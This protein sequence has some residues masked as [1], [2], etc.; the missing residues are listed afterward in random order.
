MQLGFNGVSRRPNKH[1]TQNQKTIN[2]QQNTAMFLRR[3]KPTDPINSSSQPPN[4]PEDAGIEFFLFKELLAHIDEIENH[5]LNSQPFTSDAEFL[6]SYEYLFCVMAQIDNIKKMFQSANFTRN[7]TKML[8]DELTRLELLLDASI[9][10]RS[11]V[12]NSYRRKELLNSDDEELREIAA[13]DCLIDEH[14]IAAYASVTD[15]L[16]KPFRNRK[17]EEAEEE[18]E[19]SKEPATTNEKKPTREAWTPRVIRMCHKLGLSD[20]EER[21]MIYILVAQC[22]TLY[23]TIDS[24]SMISTAAIMGKFCQMT[25]TELIHFLSPSRLHCKQELIEIESQ[26]RDTLSGSLIKMPKE[27]MWALLGAQLSASEF[28]KIDK[29]VVAEVLL[30]EPG[31][32]IHGITDNEQLDDDEN[33]AKTGEDEHNDDGDEYELYPT[34]GEVQDMEVTRNNNGKKETDDANDVE[35]KQVKIDNSS[36]FDLYDYLKEESAKNDASSQPQESSTTKKDILLAEEQFLTPYKTDIEYLDDRFQFLSSR[37]KIRNMESEKKEQESDVGYKVRDRSTDSILRE[38]HAKE[39]MLKSKSV[40]RL[41]NSRSFVPRLERL[42]KI[43]NLDEFEKMIL[44]LLVAA[45][46]SHDVTISVSQSYSIRSPKDITVGYVLWILCDTLEER[47]IHRRYFYKKASLVKDGMIRISD[48]LSGD[49][50]ECSVNIDRRMLDYIAGLDSE[51]SE[52]VEGSNLYFPQ[53]KLENVILPEE[54]KKLIIDT[55][56]NFEV[57]KQHRKKLGFDDLLTYGTSLTLMFF[58]A[59]GVG[60]VCFCA[61]DL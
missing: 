25:P 21:A 5:D 13:Q 16:S 4:N 36:E 12:T 17:D 45:I 52:I 48:L 26:Y 58:G 59:S 49:L 56:S 24:M 60:K 19:A 28:L 7:E 50:T 42:A 46:I 37:I 40:K 43:R 2:T 33:S 10:V 53:V 18:E 51:F 11:V 22:G 3:N 39:R 20:K 32:S 29:T 57:Y 31:F 35:K 15:A 47:L 6:Q 27:C 44:I 8:F 30:E 34:D 54:Q 41:A 23:P 9:M 1:F 61:F 55:V 38:L 14:I